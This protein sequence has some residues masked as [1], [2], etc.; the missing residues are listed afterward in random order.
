MPEDNMDR[1]IRPYPGSLLFFAYALQWPLPLHCLRFA[2]AF[3]PLFKLGRLQVFIAGLACGLSFPGFAGFFCLG[4]NDREEGA[5]AENPAL[6]AGARA[7]LRPEGNRT[8]PER[9][10]LMD[11]PMPLK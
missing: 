6:R 5:Y 9:L 8:E 1:W 2:E 7:E 4:G 10:S 11:C 3:A